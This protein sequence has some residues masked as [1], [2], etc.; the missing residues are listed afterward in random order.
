MQEPIINV[1]IL[2]DNQIKVEL[3][4]EFA[5]NFSEKLFNGPI[6]ARIENDKMYLD[7]NGKKIETSSEVVFSPT[8]NTLD[9]FIIKDV[10][11][12]IQFHWQ[13][14]EKQSFV[15]KLKLIFAESRYLVRSSRSMKNPCKK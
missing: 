15:G 6:T 8:D 11:I 9:T 12:G 1:G 5:A 13:K 7:V 14:K 3:H 10:I 4:G 2:T